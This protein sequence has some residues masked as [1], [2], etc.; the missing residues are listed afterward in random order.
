MAVITDRIREH[1]V[2]AFRASAPGVQ[3][4]LERLPV[5]TGVDPERLHAG[6]LIAARGNLSLFDDAIEHARDDWRDLLDRANLA[7]ADWPERI[8]AQFGSA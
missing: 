6:V 3:S 2:E 5:G 8:D 1:L 4:R 7:D